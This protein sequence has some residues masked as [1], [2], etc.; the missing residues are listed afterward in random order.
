MITSD[1]IIKINE[2]EFFLLFNEFDIPTP[3]SMNYNKCFCDKK[4]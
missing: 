3:S 4:F 1:M 2:R